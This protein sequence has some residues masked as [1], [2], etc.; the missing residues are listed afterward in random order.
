MCFSLWRL[1]LELRLIFLGPSLICWF[2]VLILSSRSLDSWT[3]SSGL[4]T[5]GLFSRRPAGIPL[6]NAIFLTPWRNT[7]AATVKVVTT[8][9]AMDPVVGIASRPIWGHPQTSLANNLLVPLPLLIRFNKHLYSGDSVTTF[10]FSGR[11]FFLKSSDQLLMQ[12]VA[13]KSEICGLPH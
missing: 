1:S 3:S 7:P 13:Y 8:K 9:T 10:H 4:E 2:I 5:Y 11:R 12:S 6:G